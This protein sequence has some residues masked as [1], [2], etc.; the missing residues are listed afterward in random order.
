[1][2]P[3][4]CP[5]CGYR[6]DVVPCQGTY[7]DGHGLRVP[8]FDIQGRSWF[9]GTCNLVFHG[10]EDEW[11]RG[12]VGGHLLRDHRHHGGLA[13]AWRCWPNKAG[14]D[15]APLRREKGGILTGT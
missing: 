6:D 9:C 7:D 5:A 1:M 3:P 10:S 12:R 13:N 14:D 2:S 15:D 11:R 4:S 8:Y